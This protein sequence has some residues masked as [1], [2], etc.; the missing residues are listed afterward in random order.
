MGT[1]PLSFNPGSGVRRSL[2]A[3]RPFWALLT[4]IIALALS[5]MPPAQATEGEDGDDTSYSFR[6]V[7]NISTSVYIRCGL[8]GDWTTASGYTTQELSCSEDEAQVKVGGEG[9][10]TAM[11][12]D[13]ESDKPVLRIKVEWSR[14]GGAAYYVGCRT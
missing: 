11:T 7:N 8:S 12:N 13:C 14:V 3:S 4:L 6:L 5:G 1:I 2:L 9:T 10:P